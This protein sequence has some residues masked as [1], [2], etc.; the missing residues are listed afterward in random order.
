MIE[1]ETFNNCEICIGLSVK[2][3][4]GSFKIEPALCFNNGCGLRKTEQYCPLI[5]PDEE[6]VAMH[7]SK[8]PG[9][10]MTLKPTPAITKFIDSS[11]DNFPEAWYTVHFGIQF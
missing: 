2:A 9:S 7:W 11:M 5:P 4:L 3:V 6:L 10:L 1:L 8:R